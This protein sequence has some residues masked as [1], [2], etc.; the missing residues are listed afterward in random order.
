MLILPLGAQS[1]KKELALKWSERCL[2]EF[3]AQNQK[4][5]ELCLP[6]TPFMDGLDKPAARM[7]LQAGFVTEIVLPIWSALAVCFPQLSFTVSQ[8]LKNKAYYNDE[9]LKFSNETAVTAEFLKMDSEEK[10]DVGTT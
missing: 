9:A 4:E 8:L 7:M 2:A 6:L 5:K 10:Y 3:Q 1:Q